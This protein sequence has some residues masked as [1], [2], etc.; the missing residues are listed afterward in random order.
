MLK[1]ELT[2]YKRQY[3]LSTKEVTI[4]KNSSV[5]KVCDTHI[6]TAEASL[7]VTKKSD[8]TRNL[9]LLG[10]LLDPHNPEYNN[11]KIVS[12]LLLKSNNFN[13]ITLNTH[14]LGGK[15]ILIYYSDSEG[16]NI[17]ND[18][19]GSRQVYFTQFENETWAA[20]QPHVLAQLCGKPLSNNPDI[21]DYVTSEQFKFTERAWIG[22][23]SRYQDVYHLL[24]NKYLNCTTARTIRFWPVNRIKK[25]TLEQVVPIISKS[26]QGIL[27]SANNRFKLLLAVSAGWDSRVLLAASKSVINDCYCFIQKFDSMTNSHP[28]I[29]IPSKLSKKLKFNFN[30]RDAKNYSGEFETALIKSVD[31]PQSENKRVLY[32]DFFSGFKDEVNISGVVGELC[33][34][35]FGDKREVSAKKL[36]AIFGRDDSTYAVQM[37]QKWLDE[38]KINNVEQTGVNIWD[39]FYWEQFIG[40][41]GVSGQASSDIAIEEFFPFNCRNIIELSYGL[42]DLAY[43]DSPLFIALI[44]HMWPE[45]L[46]EPVNP[47]SSFEKYI[48]LCKNLLRKIGVFNKIRYIYFKLFR[49]T[50]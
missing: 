31:I 30:I 24:P 11:D 42:D 41:W 27:S 2:L 12:D 49:G 43:E 29:D 8:E 38:V 46:S 48:T 34:S 19:V 7:T 23:E 16:L 14:S 32:Y 17:V 13:E 3:V 37:T 35:R 21:E 47:K 4:F 10:F 15:W 25:Q 40:N 33:R 1:N 20:S 6:L 18:I 28:D 5:T 45:A 44:N 36:S 26:L 9:I 50:S 39:L 22:D